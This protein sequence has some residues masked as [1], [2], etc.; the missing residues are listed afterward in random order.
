M[1]LKPEGHQ[2]PRAPMDRGDALQ[3]EGEIETDDLVNAVA[4][5]LEQLALAADGLHHE[6]EGS[7]RRPP[8]NRALYAVIQ[9][10][11]RLPI[12]AGLALGF[13]FTELALALA[14]LDAGSRPALFDHIPTRSGAPGDLP[15]Q[16]VR[17]IA[18]AGFLELLREHGL[19]RSEAAKELST[20]FGKGGILSWN[21]DREII[22]VPTKRLYI[23]AK[24]ADPSKVEQFVSKRLGMPTL[25]L[26]QDAIADWSR[27]WLQSNRKSEKV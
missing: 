22:N 5:L 16:E 17:D 4:Q 7:E 9:F 10:I 12:G 11:D 14:Q 27:I 2:S 3:I 6:L 8:I 19:T 1:S 25:A 20:A 26:T 18:A 13:P 15:V 23:W 21:R 24:R